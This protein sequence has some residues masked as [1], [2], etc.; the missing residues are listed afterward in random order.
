MSTKFIDS[1]QQGIEPMLAGVRKEL[2][3][4]TADYVYEIKWD[5]IR[6]VV[7]K[8]GD[9][10]TIKS[11]SGR[12]ITDKFPEVNEAKFCRVQHA[13]FDAELVCLDDQGRPVF[14]DVISRMHR[15]G[16]IDA[17]KKSK[18]VYLYIFDCMHIDAKN[19]TALS[20]MQRRDL[21][22]PILKFGNT[23][24]ISNLFEDGKQIYEA[25]KANALEG[26]MAKQRNPICLSKQ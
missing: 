21:M 16:N 26:I 3:E 20:F 9:K 6:V 13:I 25:A 17:A 5:G 2:P 23:V 8:D 1:Y 18:P 14:S 4:N 11:R 24:R 10:L 22:R 12:D 19:L 15:V 7:Y